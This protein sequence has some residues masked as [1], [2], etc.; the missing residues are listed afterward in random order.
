MPNYR[1]RA[2]THMR[3]IRPL[4]VIF[5]GISGGMLA[6]AIVGLLETLF[7][8]VTSGGTASLSALW[9]G[10]LAYGLA[11]LVIAFVW[12]IIRLPRKLEANIAWLDSFSV[13]APMLAV[14]I[15][16]FRVRRDL[17]N[18]TVSWFEPAGW[19][20]LVGALV[21]LVM[22]YLAVRALVRRLADAFPRL[23]VVT[24]WA[25]L[26]VLVV[27]GWFLRSLSP[28]GPGSVRWSPSHWKGTGSAPPNVLLI[29]VDT[30]REDVLT[31]GT[32]HRVPTPNID[33]LAASGIRFT[34]CQAQSSKTRPSVTSILTSLYPPAHGVE[35]KMDG[36][37]PD[38][39]HFPQILGEMG[40]STVGLINNINLTPF[41]GFDHGFDVYRYLE[42][43]LY[44][45]ANDDAS[46]LVIYGTARKLMEKARAGIYHVRHYYWEGEAVANLTSRWLTASPP[47]PFFLWVY[48]MDPH[49]PYFEHPYNGK[50][51]ARVVNPDPPIEQLPVL[52]DRYSGEV[53][54]M[55]E[56]VGRILSALQASGKAENTIV[57]FTADHGEEFLD[58]GGWWHGTTL[59]QE[60]VH[61]PLIIRLPQNCLA[62]TVRN[63]PVMGVDIAPTVLDL[64]SV[65]RPETWA[66][67]P[68]FSE[69]AD[70]DRVRFSEVDHEGN[71]VRAIRQGDWVWIEANPG[72]PRGLPGFALYN[73]ATDPGEHAD[74]SPR[75]PV[76]MAQM[77][78]LL[79]DVRAKALAQKG[80]IPQMAIDQATEE[81]LRA[82]G[83][84]K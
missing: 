76:V 63:D 20:L 47:Q 34:N 33:A 11:G 74:V 80:V 49:D 44:F 2:T 3:T 71:Q 79:M 31:Q 25:I 13:M 45:G 10:A 72:N 78:N 19:L 58:H 60:A 17:L 83:Y 48:L 57:I 1:I 38:L 41:F 77:R 35:K 42:P 30:L 12:S 36:Y 46:N 67:I 68:L 29:V 56:Q 82:L 26:L 14:S 59:Y 66:G 62:G 54:Y 9:F 55:D 69:V 21:C 32:R 28:V 81:R 4:S 18:E 27:I 15:V 16:L 8:C 51:T 7:L 61:V 6:G 64:V 39:V 24:S 37:P 50:A 84:T 70:S 65:P 53:R 52:F 22:G 40:Y 73:L 23:L 43:S 75:N 5:A